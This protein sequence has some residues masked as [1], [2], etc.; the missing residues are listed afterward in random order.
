M[1]EPPCGDSSFLLKD[2]NE[3]HWSGAKSTN[4]ESTLEIG[5]TRLKSGRSDIALDQRSESMCC[6]DKIL[7][8]NVLG[9]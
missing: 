1:S 6:S 3:Y 4:N 2:N 9:I 7:L 8:W 5:I